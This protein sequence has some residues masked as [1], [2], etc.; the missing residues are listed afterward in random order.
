MMKK[1]I[2]IIGMGRESDRVKRIGAIALVAF[3]LPLSVICAQNKSKQSNTGKTIV[4]L[5]RDAHTKQPI[6][7]AEISVPNF[8]ISA[9]TDDKGKF[10]IKVSSIRSILRV[11]AYDY[12][13]QEITLRGKDSIIVDLYSDVFTNKYK[14][15]EGLTGTTD[16]SSIGASANSI[17]DL[18]LSEAVAAD[19][20][21]QTALG[22][23]VRAITRSGLSGE[24]ASLF[25]RGLNS[26]NA[27]AQPLFVV[28]GVIWN[29]Q[30][31]A[32]S[33]H[34]GYFANTLNSIDVND[35]ESISLLKDGTSL[36]GSKGGNG[37][38]LI[39][40]KRAKSMVTKINVSILHGIVGQ[41]KTLPLMNGEE[42]RSYASDMF[43][44]KGLS[45]SEVS[46]MGFLQ[47]NKS[48]PVYN[49]YHNNTDWS[50]VVYQRG[51][52]KSY[53]INVTGG[54]EK[55][56]YYLSLGYTGNTGI[57]KTT[58]LQRYNARFNADFKM[59]KDLSLGM[60]IGFTRNERILQDDGVNN[61]TSPTWVSML[62]S[63][64]LSM[65]KFTNS[66]QIT[67]NYAFADEF[68]ISNPMGVIYNAVNNLKQY[69]FNIGLLPTYKITPELS[70]SSQFDY[71]LDKSVEGHFDPYQYVP[72]RELKDFGAFYNKTSS[73]VMRNTAIYDDTRLTYEK[74]FNKSNHLKAILGWRYMSN[75][76]ESDYLA[77]YNSKSN[78]KTT[79]TGDYEFLT[80]TGINNLTNS[81]S[82]Y[83]NAEYNYDNRI[84]VNAM[85]AV[86]GSS[87][88][89]NETRGGFQLFG[90]SW[91]VFP[92]VNAGWLLSSERFMKNVDVINYCKL[93]AG[94]GLTGN[95]GLQ[96]YQSMAYFSSVRLMNVANGLAIDNVAN[97]KLQ[98]ETTAKAN[99]GLDLSILNDRASFNFDYFSNKTS[100][101]LTL[102][103]LPEVTGLG[104]YW[105]NGGT[106]TN[107]GFEF[108]ANVK[109]LNS[110]LLKWELG[111][112]V[113]HYKNQITTL[114][115]GDYT[116]SVYEGEVLTA[117][118]QAAGTFYG[119]KTLGVFST[120]P[121]AAVANLKTKISDG[122]YA[123]FGAG[124]IHFV[125]VNKDG[126]IDAKDKQVIGN[127]NP[128]VYGTI[129][130]KIAV[131]KLTLNTIFTYSLGNDIYNYYRS[132]LES[133]KD[134]SNQ[135]TAMNARWTADGQ[136]TSQ[137][138]AVYGDPM[139]N[140]RFSD[141]WIEDG[142][143]LKLKTVSL[144]YDL[145]LKNNFIQGV[146]LWVSANN[147]VTLTKYLGVDP[148]VSAKNSV[149]YQGVDAG[150][151]PAT[152][153][154]YFG[155][156]LNL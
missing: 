90:H 143:Y 28:D 105:S 1:Y 43:G 25:V 109:A 51:V 110:K 85:A 17:D 82:N 149:Y 152:R 57:V 145:A 131:K 35:I 32:V 98:W 141:R 56:M 15:I 2:N 74:T 21:L 127:P 113:G 119:Y 37:V 36:Y 148:E 114:P 120:S 30:Y 77:E 111:L 9:V 140:A 123:T 11:S 92:S 68:G 156:K 63:P 26:L 118:G 99:V 88:F 136:I 154:Y 137:P 16:N 115:N 8:M 95:D 91:G 39:K 34:D 54:D 20:A 86:D 133:G 14:K 70:L 60:N 45:G 128:D 102:K 147:L 139:G 101:L 13:P 125:D 19:D 73:Q 52:N 135:S 64:F 130:S 48:N 108:S 107:K 116:T 33:L 112:S 40:T 124:D 78:N 117:V 42:F 55:A 72:T 83:L 75:Y 93:R 10:S 100:D 46:S 155:I 153:S 71:N 144:S 81:L 24:G 7:A 50:D 106:M 132:Q 138:K 22:G 66:G 5:V 59:M 94:Y 122:T 146:T 129:T 134:L 142:S 49:T 151:L 79:I 47:T 58:D 76:Y 96:D 62:K 18:S 69:R 97:N 84:F 87:R 38:I 104:K 12:N 65:Y 61:Y 53:S 121:E 4:G 29:N 150:L 41:P 3:I 27:N 6:S 31:D 44:S 23:N 103:D 126:I 80:T 67:H 89:G